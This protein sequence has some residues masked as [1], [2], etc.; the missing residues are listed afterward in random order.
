MLFNYEFCL[1]KVVQGKP[2]GKHAMIMTIF[3]QNIHRNTISTVNFFI[4]DSFVHLLQLYRV[5][6]P[7][8]G[9]LPKQ[10]KEPNKTA[11]RFVK[12]SQQ[13][14]SQVG[15]IRKWQHKIR[16]HWRTKL[17]SMNTNSFCMVDLDIIYYGSWYR[18]HVTCNMVNG[19]N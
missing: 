4:Y 16:L 18:T 5:F 7:P 19:W 6:F 14:L 2:Q 1:F 10:P 17:M 9:S 12:N 13:F 8:N 15:N 11:Q 3:T